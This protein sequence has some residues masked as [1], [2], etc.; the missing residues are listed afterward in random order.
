MAQFDPV[1]LPLD[2]LLGVLA[3]QRFYLGVDTHL[4][5][6]R[7]L[8]HFSRQAEGSLDTLRFQLAALLCHS[9]DEQELFYR[10]FDDFARAFFEDMGQGEVDKPPVIPKDN[11][12]IPPIAPSAPFMPPETKTSATPVLP[13]ATVGRSGPIR[14]ELKFPA[15]PLRI[16]NTAEMDQAVRPLREKEWTPV[17]EWDIPAT[18][19]RTIRAGGMPTFEMRRRKRPPQYL[20]LID[21]K[22]PRDHLAGLY[23]ELAVELN[24]RDITAEYFFYDA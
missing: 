20:L 3:T 7:F 1:F 21:Q 12:E 24:R 6:Q 18:I 22:S 16:W 4:R 15:N 17:Q 23:A 9:A 5:L 2:E 11:R 19:L 13:A 10:I 14:V 8:V